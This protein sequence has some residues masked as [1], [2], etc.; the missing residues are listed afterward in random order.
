M[1]MM[2]ISRML[3]FFKELN[4]IRCA[5][6]KFSEL[7]RHFE[8]ACDLLN[9]IA[10]SFGN[11]ANNHFVDSIERLDGRYKIHGR[12]H[13]NEPRFIIIND[14]GNAEKNYV[15]TL[16]IVERRMYDSRVELLRHFNILLPESP[17]TPTITA[18]R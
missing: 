8:S 2:L 11:R 13:Y 7:K 17:P 9:Q 16:G 4:I 5:S 15:D 12:N 18:R 6:D 14:D 10:F 3:H 1:A